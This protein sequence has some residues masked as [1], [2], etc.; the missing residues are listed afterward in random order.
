M[1]EQVFDVLPN[2]TVILGK[3]HVNIIFLC[4]MIDKH[5]D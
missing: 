3:L 5:F 4:K 2:Y 1:F